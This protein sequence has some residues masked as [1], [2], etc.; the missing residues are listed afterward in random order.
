MEADLRDSTN[1]PSGQIRVGT[2]PAF[3][4]VHMVP[5]VERFTAQ[6][7]DIRIVL[8]LDVGDLSLIK[9]GLDLSVRISVEVADASHVSIPLASAPQVLVAAPSY[10]AAHGVPATP[11]A[12]ADHRCLVHTIKSP[13]GMWRFHGPGGPQAVRV[14][15]ALSAD[16]GEP[17]HAAALNGHGI[18][19][20]PYYMVQ[21]DLLEGRLVAV[22]PE[23][24]PEQ[25]DIHVIYSNRNSLPER[26]RRFLTFLRDGFRLPPLWSVPDPLG[27][28]GGSPA[29]A[30]RQPL[31][32]AQSARR[33][34]GG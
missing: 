30:R 18:A 28:R 15:G 31:R 32:R 4:A 33:R 1:A 24:A 11:D 2:P 23:Y 34:G 6:H 27:L 22:L 17:L 3:G 29:A 14:G 16:F 25:H 21:D 13:T 10:L 5:L 26:A 7:P 19:M 8:V 20:H 9:R 12:L